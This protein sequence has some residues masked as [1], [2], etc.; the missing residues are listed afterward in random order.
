MK[1]V[2]QPATQ[3]PEMTS[4]H[5]STRVGETTVHRTATVHPTAQLGKGV[6][7]GP[8]VVIERD[9]IIGD[10][11]VIG[12]HTVI[13]RDVVVGREN[14][15]GVG[16]V[17]GSPPQ[18]RQYAGERTFALIG[19]R[20]I[21]S[22]YSAVSRAY[23]EGEATVLGN[24]NFIMP[25]TRIDH[26]C[27]V[28]NNT[29]LVGR[30]GLAGYVTVD[31][32]AY[33]GAH[34]AVHQFVRIGRLA[35]VGMVSAVRQDVP[36]FVLAAGV[37]ARAHAVNTVGLVRAAVPAANRAILHRAFKLL[38]RSGLAVSTALA[39][40]EAELGDDPYV[41]EMITFIRAGTHKRGIVRWA[42]E[43]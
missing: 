26:N 14:K 10:G 42:H 36:P 17:L 18:H 15:L 20:N 40:I 25:Y 1:L 8:Y 31:D 34:T 28:G 21:L 7:V 4:E 22:D 43:K 11:T 19:D 13:E 27:R 35:I 5:T 33:L 9:V 3:E 12:P 38:Y 37:P 30:V 24:D 2:A 32:Q 16:V 29:I 6:E 39:R 23:G 41:Q